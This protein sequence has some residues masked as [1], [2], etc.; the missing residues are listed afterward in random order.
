MTAVAS[1]I[2][3]EAPKTANL[4]IGFRKVMLAIVAIAA[5]MLIALQGG[6][7]A[8]AASGDLT[9]G[10][11]TTSASAST[12]TVRYIAIIGADTWQNGDGSR[13]APAS[14]MTALARVDT[15]AGTVSILTFPRDMK[16]NNMRK[17][18]P[19]ATN[20]KTNM[21][22]R[23]AFNNA[24]KA[25]WSNYEQA[26]RKAAKTTCKELKDITGINV[27]DYAVVDL[28][29]YQDIV[30]KL[31]GVTVNIPVGIQNYRLYSNGKYYSVNKGKTGYFK[32]KG[33]DAM[34]A[35][36]NREAYCKW[37]AATGYN[38]KYADLSDYNGK[39]S[40]LLIQKIDANGNK[41][42]WYHF[43]GD[44]TRQFLDR[45]TFGMLVS[46]A[47]DRSEGAWTFV[48]DK[49]I[50][51]KLMWT[52]LSKDDVKAIGNGLSKA[53]KADK[54]VVYGAS[55]ISPD[56]G[57]NYKLHGVSQYLIPL[58]KANKKQLKATVKQFKAGNPM[59]SGWAD[60]VIIGAAKGKKKKSGGITY[61]VTS[62]AAV[63]VVKIPNKKTVVIPSKV[64]INHKYYKVTSIAANSMKGSKV[65]S[66]V[67]GSYVSKIA[68]KAFKGSK[69]KK[70][71]LKTTRLTK[72]K[73]K[74]SLKGSVVKTI[75]V[76]VPKAQKKGTVK[77]YKK[78][79]TKA[80]AGC[81]KK[82]KIS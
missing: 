68:S 52:S 76:S 42:Y 62:N 8:Y 54:L 25:D 20:Y 56:K 78:Y 10:N 24:I 79:F 45:R 40:N 13:H 58:D 75:K 47:L 3:S 69:V 44:G 15:K 9:V 51:T 18:I 28:Y 31:G 34:I 66:V 74:G 32:L 26:L 72:A 12:S 60:E 35:A 7:Q 41:E 64:K 4:S 53:K 55:V 59:T 82:P 67:L 70:I 63:S 37:D 1:N 50:Q 73:V 29:T 80:N 57:R 6:Q 16:Y 46:K 14:D 21:V 61:K 77:L 2:Y 81:S 11:V 27:K 43:D 71:T 49:M 65:R 19:G 36:R 38:I 39:Y 48:W 5:V 23:F 30:N 17:L 33:W 22:F